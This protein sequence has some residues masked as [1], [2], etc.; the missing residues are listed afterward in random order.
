MSCFSPVSIWRD[1]LVGPLPPKIDF[2][3]GEL[4]SGSSPISFSFRDGWQH[5][6]IGCGRCD[7][8]RAD[9]ALEWS[10]RCYH[11]ASLFDRNSF[12]TLT[13]EDSPPALVKADLQKFFKRLRHSYKFRYFA[14]GEYGDRTRRP[15]YHAL[16]FGED[17]LGGDVTPINDKL[18]T[19]AAVADCWGHGLVSIAEVNMS[20]CCYVAG[21]VFKK[22]GDTDTFSL[23]SRR[24]GIGHDWLDR[25]A[26]DLVRT[27]TVTIEGREYPIPRRYMAWEDWKFHNTKLE[28]AERMQSRVPSDLAGEVEQTRSR[29]AKA[30]N[31]SASMKLREKQL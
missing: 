30:A 5:L 3:T 10:L 27:G 22:I 13:Y 25:F 18:Y 8:C 6:A 11:E 14:C 7:G 31:R 19:N 17:F 21:Y 1:P 23:Q 29:K 12:L 16:I 4:L 26:G 2:D 15:H 28:R 24:P 20:T 9:R